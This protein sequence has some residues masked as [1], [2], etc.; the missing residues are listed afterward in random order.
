[1]GGQRQTVS[2]SGAVGQWQ[3]V[4]PERGGWTMADGLAGARRAAK[5]GRLAEDEADGQQNG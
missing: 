2:G 3:T 1:M 5:G 4:W